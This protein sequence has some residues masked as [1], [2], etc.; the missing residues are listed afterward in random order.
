MNILMFSWEYPPRIIGGISRVVYHLSRELSEQGHNVTVITSID[1]EEEFHSSGNKKIYCVS[2][3]YVKPINFI[4]GV[5][6]MNLSMLEKA[7]E[8]IKNGEMFDIIHLHDWL[9]AFVGKCMSRIYPIKQ[10]CTIHSTEYGRNA[11]IHNEIQ[12]FIN[13]VEKKMVHAVKHVIVNSMYMKNEVETLFERSPDN[14]HVIP[15]GIEPGKL[16]LIPKDMDFRR[17]YASD[18]EK[19]VFFIGRLVNEKGVHVLM[20]AV[21][22]ILSEYRDVRFVI[23]GSGPERDTLEKKAFENGV[24]ERVHF[25]GYINDEELHKMYKS[26]DIAVFPSLYEPFGIVALE[27]MVANLPVVVSEAGGF[28][29]IV[30]NRYNGMKFRTG[31]SD[32]LADC[33]I[34]LLTTPELA[35]DITKNAWNTIY[36]KYK[37]SAIVEKTYAIY[38]LARND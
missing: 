6:Q 4:N 29:E 13:N 20:D 36:E 18:N 26:V 34:E 37:W 16:N 1:G 35:A 11:G 33:I 2:S 24:A 15:N 25:T 7:V 38:E 28:N 9:V 14:I 5:L 30:T 27:A 3:Y 8:I 32:L 31:H 23:A 21:P 22:I 19:I 10:V 17:K 12:L